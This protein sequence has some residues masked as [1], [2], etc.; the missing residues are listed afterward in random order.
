MSSTHKPWIANKRVGAI[1][2]IGLLSACG[3]GGG[4]GDGGLPSP[5]PSLIRTDYQGVWSAPAYGK[6]LEIGA[7]SARWYDVSSDFCLLAASESGLDTDDIETL[8]RLD[9]SILE[10]FGSNGTADFAAPGERFE[11]VDALPTHC[12]DGLT[13]RVGDAAYRRDA[14]RE[15]RLYAQWLEEYSV[16]PGLRGVDMRALY[17]EQAVALSADSEDAALV[18]ALYQLT[19]PLA[20]I[21]TRV[22]T[23]LGLVR[24]E[25]KPTLDWLLAAE[26]LAQAGL[27]E[28]LTEA[29][30]Q[31]VN[32]Y[33][34]EQRELD[35]AVTLSYA[36]SAESVRQ[37]ASGQLTWF[38]NAGL[39]YLAIDA[40]TGFDAADDNTAQLD[41][42]DAALDQ[43]LSDLEGI[44]GL[45]IDVRRNGGGQDFLALAVAGR[46]A[47]NATLAY[48]KQARLGDARTASVDVWV[49]PRGARQ[50]LGPVALLTSASTVS[51]AEVFTL[52][53]RALPQ[54]TLIGEAT[55]GALSDQLQARLS[56][57]WAFSLANEYYLTPEGEWYEGLGIPADLTVLQ[58][59]REARLAG[60]DPALDVAVAWL[61]Q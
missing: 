25:N 61:M 30:W 36:A 4:G 11:R 20:D 9:G 42:L 16:H 27:E 52:A 2:V 49:E 12:V 21:H 17:A 60:E 33:V 24:V 43:A 8:Y 59:S 14:A 47:A 54:V 51:A 28:P 46:F 6:V 50:F 34:G 48:R 18:E 5:G 13:A 39:G 38:A 26:Y 56:N 29:Q 57:G 31:Q 7:S 35:R 3:G 15:L 53:M 32:D 1:A 44:G 45:I 22:E 37:G 10:E 41:A 40:M 58:F 23:P 55:Q 19:V